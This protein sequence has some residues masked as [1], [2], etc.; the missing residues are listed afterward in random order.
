MQEPQITQSDPKAYYYWLQSQG[1]N[2]YQA[3]ELVRQRFPAPEQKT[4]EQVAKEQG[5]QQQ[6][7]AIA[8]T[9]GLVGGVVAGRYVY[10]KV[11]GWIDSATGTK[12]AEQTVQQ[13]AQQAG[14]AGTQATTTATTGVATAAPVAAQAASGAAAPSVVPQGGEIPAGYTAVGSA[15]NG[16]TIVAPDALASDK[17]FMDSMTAA[18]WGAVAQ[19]ALSIYNAYQ[20]YQMGK[21]GDYAGAALTGGAA[22]TGGAAALGTAGVN[23][24][25]Q[26]TL[27][28]AAPYL[29]V[30][31]GVYGGYQTA[32]YQADAAAGAQRNRNSAV[33]GAT[34]GALIGSYFGPWGTA[35]GAA[36]GG[37]AGLAGSHFGSSKDKYQMIRDKARDGLQ[38]AN[39]LDENY[40][41]SLADGSKFDF[42]KDGK[43]YGKLNTKDPNWGTAAGLANVIAAGEGL[44]GRPLEGIATMYAN[45]AMSNSSGDV[46]KVYDN[47]RHFAAQR[48]MNLDNVTQQLDKLKTD[49]LIDDD[50]YNA[51][52]NGARTIFGTQPEQQ[53]AQI[54]VPGKGQV[55]RVSPGMYMN[56]KGRVQAAKS[57]R[58]SLEQ[59]YGK[60]KEKSR[61]K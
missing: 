22:V 29:G 49:K 38:K 55:A 61:R 51:Y 47:I 24:T 44:Y 30:A 57:V 53:Q 10:N 26:Q 54:Q 41:G 1:M 17:G 8:S 35:I 46:N 7:G 19:G 48:N 5:K 40:Q 36:V 25:G 34:S 59:N 27:A 28:A 31:A 16:G 37:L 23:F 2:A 33:G 56:D 32:K 4:P 20:A 39:I 60:S 9:A 12:V 50:Q 3:S 45:A 14:Q 13:A 42:G 18:D 21:R 11:D 52:L 6:T 58:Q 15:A 43:K